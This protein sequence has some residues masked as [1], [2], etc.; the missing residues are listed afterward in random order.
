MTERT[1]PVI[2]KPSGPAT[3]P[4][5]FVCVHFCDD[6]EHNLLKSPCVHDSLN[7]LIIV[8][9][10]QNVFFE[11]LGK[12]LVHGMQQARHDLI[13][14]VHEDVLLQEGWQE[15]FEASL[16]ALENVHPDWGMIGSVGWIEKGKPAGHWSD[17]NRL[18]PMNTFT[19]RPFEAVER[20]DEQLLVLRKS[21][22]IRP[23]PDLPSIHRI[24]RDL[25]NRL[26]KKQLKTFSIN[27]PTIHKFADSSGNL[28]NSAE[29]SDKIQKRRERTF[30]AELDVS[31]AYLNRANPLAPAPDLEAS[32]QAILDAPILLIGRGGG[33]TRLLSVVAQDCGLFIGNTVIPSGDCL[34]MVPAIYRSLLRRWKFSDPWSLS[35]I[36]D[37]L[38]SAAAAMLSEAGWPAR[39]GFK[40]PESAL[41]LPDLMDAFPKARVVHFSRDP[42]ATILR[43]SHMTARLDNEIGRATIP[44]AY[45]HIGRD[46]ANILT[47]ETLVHMAITTRHQID[48]IAAAKEN[49]VADRYLHL[50]F[51]ETIRRPQDTLDAF[52]RFT[53]LS[54]QTKRIAA[55]IDAKRAKTEIVE[56]PEEQISKAVAFL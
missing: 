28:I 29:D 43:R 53:G 9:N 18:H 31:E 21:T 23:D 19:E 48:L 25:A 46:R 55:E 38:L 40:L 41:L 24:G 49:L 54:V 26:G 45:D 17:P 56:F 4:I 51:E 12:A 1:F 14:L 2:P 22:G 8:D 34:D 27:A 6:L 11:T 42:L 30:V 7:Q 20:L 32:H 35:A 52:A 47:D 50:T 39:W 13:A 3:R 44:A 37:D 16:D 33:G 15:M 5:S 10:R 36:K